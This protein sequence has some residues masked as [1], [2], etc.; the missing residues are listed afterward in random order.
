MSSGQTNRLV[1]TLQYVAVATLILRLFIGYEWLQAGVHKLDNIIS[2]MPSYVESMTFVMTKVWAQGTETVDPNPYVFVSDFLINF[3][4]PNV[5]TV[6]LVIMSLQVIIGI[7]FFSGLLS[8]PAAVVGLVMNVIF[9]LAAGHTS[10][11][12]SG[13]NLVMIGAH[14][15]ILISSAGR[16]YGLDALLCKK[17]PRARIF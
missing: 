15:F 8:R 17:F 6:L 1:G 5:E 16:A 10:P 14:L 2:D 12:T 7:L 4:G 11:S 3:V 9:F 13:V